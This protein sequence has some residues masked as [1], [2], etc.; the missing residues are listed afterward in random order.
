MLLRSWGTFLCPN[1]YLISPRNDYYGNYKNITIYLLFFQVSIF[2]HIGDI[3]HTAK[4]DFENQMSK[5]EVYIQIFL[6]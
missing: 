2:D 6:V 3:E 1:F 4:N 5:L